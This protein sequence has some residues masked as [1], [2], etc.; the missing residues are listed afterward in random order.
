VKGNDPLNHDKFA[1]LANVASE[2]ERV[3]QEGIAADKG[4]MPKNQ[5]AIGG[6]L[7]SFITHPVRIIHAPEQIASRAQP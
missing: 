7:A 6:K 5:T 3:L 4:A 1:Q 2:L